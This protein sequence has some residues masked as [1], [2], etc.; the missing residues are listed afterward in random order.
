[1]AGLTSTGFVTKTI[2]EIRAEIQTTF[3]SIFGADVALHPQ[4]PNGQVIDIMAEREASLWDAL[5]ASYAARDPAAATGSELDAVAYFTGTARREATKSRVSLSL[6]GTA[7]T[8]IP[9]GKIVSVGGSSVRFVTLD[10]VTLDGLGT[11][12]VDAEA[13]TAGPITANWGTVTSIETPVAGWTAVTNPLDAN[14][15]ENEETDAA[16]RVRREDELRA[17]GSAHITAMVGLL[18][19]VDGVTSAEGFEN[20]TSETDGDGLPPHSVEMVVIGGD[21]QPIFETIF[22]SKAAGIETYGTT[23]G[24][25]T[26][27]WGQDHTIKFSRQTDVDIY[28]A[29]D[30]IVDETLFPADGADQIAAAIAAYGDDFPLG[31]DVVSSAMVP[32]IFGIPGVID[33][34][35]VN[36]DT[37]ASPTG[38]A[39]IA[40]APRSRAVFDTGRMTVGVTPGSL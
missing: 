12:T 24:T 30:V 31:R 37:S 5:E 27:D 15:G 13:E 36:I 14:P 6:T 18:R 23:S 26:D 10:D 2:A 29:V 40:I 16:L 19:A 25:V 21:D 7:G 3:R 33:V 32:S 28:V 9:A 1:M 22:A 39:T 20:V 34:T 4:S 35:A 17:Q 8:L 11:G 38:E